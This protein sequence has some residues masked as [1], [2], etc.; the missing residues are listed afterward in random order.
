MKMGIV[1][2]FLFLAANLQ[3]Q[4]IPAACYIGRVSVAAQ[5]KLELCALQGIMILNA[6]YYTA[7]NQRIN[8]TVCRK[9]LDPPTWGTDRVLELDNTGYRGLLRDVYQ[10]EEIRI[11]ITVGQGG[12][13]YF[14]Q[15]TFR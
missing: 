3:A 13:Y 14:W 5:R 6:R 9:Y 12:R 1:M 11:N 4:E 15:K 8:T 2:L 10:T 7:D